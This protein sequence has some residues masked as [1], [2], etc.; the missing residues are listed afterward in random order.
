MENTMLAYPVG[1]R[2][3]VVAGRLIDLLV[4]GF[5]ILRSAKHNGGVAA[6][7]ESPL[8]GRSSVCAE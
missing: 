5:S 2:A 4:K 7:V 1:R 6:D 3:Y 8:A